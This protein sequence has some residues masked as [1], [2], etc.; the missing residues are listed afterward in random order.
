[1]KL[2]KLERKLIFS[3][4][5]LVCIP[6]IF[7]LY[8]ISPNLSFTTPVKQSYLPQDTIFPNSCTI[9]SVNHSNKAFFGNNEDYFL[10]GTYMWLAPSQEITTPNGSIITY[11]GV[12][13]GFK[14][15]DDP[16]DG[17]IQGGMND[18]G[19]CLDGNGLP[20]V[21][22]NP[23]PELE[24]KYTSLA[25]QI[26]M[27]CQNVSEV[28]D[29]F[30][31]HYLGDSWGC[32]VHIA[33]ASGDAVVVSVGLEG[34]F[35]FT[36]KVNSN[37]LVSTNF[38]LVNYDN[39]Y[40]PCDRYTTACNMLEDIT[41]EENLTVDACRDILDSVHMEGDF[42]TKYSNIF[43]LVNQNCYLFYNHDFN[44]RF[45]FNLGEELAKVYPGGENVIEENGIFFKEILISSLFREELIIPGYSV[46]MLFAIIAF[47]SMLIIY[48]Y[49]TAKYRK[50][51]QNF[52]K[53]ATF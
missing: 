42:A 44:H 33:D 14:Y 25:A 27:E 48:R 45:A 13:F 22:L 30:L 12:G 18:Q 11:G 40:Y 23:H 51:H 38:N 24:P 26:L 31:S 28:I 20:I 36:R 37:Y 17:H 8:S 19:L 46:L 15:N 5:L 43:D 39:G 34:E 52:V 4:I 1:M 6:L 29:W 35:N 21:D 32:Q 49:E 2:Q 10:K 16:A 9:F 50:N 47:V 41:S 3:R 53:Y 7:L